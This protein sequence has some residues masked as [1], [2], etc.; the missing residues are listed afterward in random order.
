M[1]HCWS[2][3][4]SPIVYDQKPKPHNSH[5]ILNEQYPSELHVTQNQQKVNTQIERDVVGRTEYQDD[6][7]D[8]LEY[9]ITSDIIQ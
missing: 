4:E 7:Y 3:K 6:R 9:K 2:C 5:I 8:N 1:T